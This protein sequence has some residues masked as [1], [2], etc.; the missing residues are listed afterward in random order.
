MGSSTTLLI[1]GFVTSLVVAYAVV[2]WFTGYLAKHT[3][4]IFGWYRLA[5]AGL[6]VL[7]KVLP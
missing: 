1:V 5:L 4:A 2:K 7:F 3:L 6:L